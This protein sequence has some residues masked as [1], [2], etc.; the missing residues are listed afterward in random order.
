MDQAS[1]GLDA[2][3][4]SVSESMFRWYSMFRPTELPLSSE[5][6]AAGCMYASEEEYHEDP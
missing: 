2:C 5:T 4:G 1:L 6:W 3:F